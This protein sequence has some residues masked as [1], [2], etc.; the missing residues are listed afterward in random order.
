MKRFLLA[1]AAVVAFAGTSAANTI[2]TSAG[3]QS[4]V[5]SFRGLDNIGVAGYNPG[6]TPAIAGV[7]IA[8][9]GMRHF[10]G[11]GTAL[12][13]GLTLGFGSETQD[14]VTSD[15]TDD[16]QSAF[17]FG[18][19]GALE[20]YLSPPASRV[21]TYVGVGAGIGFA[22]VTDEPTRSNNPGAGTLLKDS[23]SG[24]DLGLMGMAGFRAGIF[25][26]VDL[27]GEYS[28]GLSLGSRSREV[29]TQGNPTI[30]NDGSEFSL[31]TSVA[32]LYL[33]VP[34]G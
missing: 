26:G 27:G 2:D 7:N 3:S 25:Q 8:G 18:I 13:A 1:A 33:S 19:N 21:A 31:G 23:V 5:F 20:K 12:R 4:L 10:L 9:V 22:S 15:Q 6:T 24:F 28:L 17:A 29:E 34:W 16:K 32:S 30:K 14:A 11:D